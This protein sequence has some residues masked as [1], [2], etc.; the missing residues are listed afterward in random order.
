MN[1]NNFPTIYPIACHTNNIG[2][3]STFV[4]I[5]GKSFNGRDFIIAALQ[6]GASKIVIENTELTPDIRAIV[7]KFNAEL[8][9]IHNARRALAELSAQA[10]G[11]P[12][13]S[14][15][16]IG[17]TGTKG[18][19]TT[20]YIL[21]HI[22]RMSG[23]KTALV[24]TIKNKIVDHEFDKVLTTPQ[25]D[26]LNIFFDLC[27]KEKVDYVILEVAAQALVLDRVYG[28]EF[29]AAIFTNF[30]KEHA[31]FFSTQEE[32]FQAKVKLFQQLKPNAPAI[33]NA[34]D[35]T[36]FNLQSNLKRK[37]LFGL[38]S[39]ADLKI[40]LTDVQL[41]SSIFTLKMNNDESE[42]CTKSLSGMHNIYNISAAAACAYS[43]GLS[44]EKI[45]KSLLDF[46][47]VPGRLQRFDLANG[48]TAFIDYAHNESSFEAIL[49]MLRNFTS[50]LI[51][52]F[53]CG[54]ERDATKRSCMG[55]VASNYCDKIFLTSDNPRSE[56]PLGIINNILEGVPE[57][58]RGNVC[59]ELDRERAIERSYLASD[60]NSIIAL[61][62]KG[63]DE[64]QIIKNEKK[65]FS[66]AK[67]LSKLRLAQ[68]E[69]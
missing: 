23:Y 10:L 3:G 68:I 22:L 31:E 25:P 56:D 65:Y 15:K 67:I 9:I 40:K 51:V 63:P 41:G 12:S 57:S 29:D 21:E 5:K 50:N 16:I 54:G 32:Y 2:L 38:N 59:I 62:G 13:K 8:I 55:L 61:L 35:S 20:V 45:S 42:Y 39:S 33:L 44:L 27:R 58:K 48:A 6:K 4:S 30:S 37:I 53:G 26:Y 49:S 36:L 28:I 46:S 17:V 14:L 69:K 19:S 34:D 60:A 1:Q 47:F 18:K 11:Y 52:V 7:K 66:E 43:L 64:Y 24:S